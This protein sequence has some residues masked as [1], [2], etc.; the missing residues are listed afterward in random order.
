MENASKALIIAG[1][2][3]I[4]ILIIGLGVYFYNMAASAGKKVNLDS[5]AAN[6]HNQAFTNYFGERQ[7]STDVKNLMTEIRSNNISGQT[8]GETS[9]I[10]VV[11]KGGTTAEAAIKEPSVVATSVKAGK[12]Y[13]IGVL[14]DAATEESSDTKPTAVTDPAYYNSGYIRIITINEG[15]Q[16]TNVGTVT[17]AK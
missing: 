13:W 1:A 8:A 7:S 16:P 14:N 17:A 5:Q 3:L 4:S 10:Y 11:F 15:G 12:T 2:I 6:A 9:K